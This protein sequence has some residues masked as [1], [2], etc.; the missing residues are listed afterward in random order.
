MLKANFERV[1]KS[2]FVKTRIIIDRKPAKGHVF[3]NKQDFYCQQKL[4]IIGLISSFHH[5]FHLNVSHRTFLHHSSLSR[6]V[7]FAKVRHS[8][9]TAVFRIK[10]CK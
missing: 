7:Q 1:M 6:N 10:V 3:N 4:T 9:Y 8:Y 5:Y 2:L